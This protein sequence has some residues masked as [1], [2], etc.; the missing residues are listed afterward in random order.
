MLSNLDAGECAR[1]AGETKKLGRG[2]NLAYTCESIEMD[3]LK[4]GPMNKMY[5]SLLLSGLLAMTAASAEDGDAFLKGQKQFTVLGGTGYAFD[6]SYFVLGAGI[7]YYVVD[8]LN[9]GLQLESWMGADPGILKITASSQY[10]FY[11]TQR[12]KPYIGAFYRYTDVE[13]RSS[14]DSVGGRG[15]LY[16]QVGRN[17]YAG[18]G[19]V[20]E[21]YLDC[22]PRIYGSCDET[23]PEISFLFS[24]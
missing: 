11:Q 19:V 17:G 24:F 22:N 7:N 12:V 10:V 15:G 1:A 3:I 20:Y 2:A 13:N 23:Y 6:E 9:V 8:G 16:M 14:L 21:S 5:V 18:L 4:G